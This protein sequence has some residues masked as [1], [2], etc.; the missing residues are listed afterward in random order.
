MSHGALKNLNVS[1]ATCAL[2][3]AKIPSG[4]EIA[5]LTSASHSYD[6]SVSVSLFILNPFQEKD[7]QCYG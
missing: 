5:A 3:L 4:T 2:S 1:G 6:N 7:D